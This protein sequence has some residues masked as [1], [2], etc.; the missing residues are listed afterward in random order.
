MNDVSCS[1]NQFLCFSL[2]NPKEKGSEIFSFSVIKSEIISSRSRLSIRALIRYSTFQGEIIGFIVPD[3]S[4]FFL[5]LK[6][7]KQ[8][9]KNYSFIAASRNGLS[10]WIRG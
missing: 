8:Q 4:Y 5:N 7:K 9:T 10:L 2:P 6:K 1:H 3:V